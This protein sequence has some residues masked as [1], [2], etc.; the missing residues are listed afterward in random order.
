MKKTF[1]VITITVQNRMFKC[2]GIE[3]ST[4]WRSTVEA[5][6]AVIWLQYQR[7]RKSAKWQ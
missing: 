5:V 7:R 1:N 6:R 2:W 4:S 3:A